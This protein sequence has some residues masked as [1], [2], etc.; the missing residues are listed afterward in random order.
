MIPIGA[1]RPH[2]L[3]A[4]FDFNSRSAAFFNA[5]DFESRSAAFL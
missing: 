3:K 4:F 5:V 1:K 2:S